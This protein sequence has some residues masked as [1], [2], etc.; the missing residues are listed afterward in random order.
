MTKL[1]KE[2]K[3]MTPENIILREATIE[4]A[5]ALLSIY[6]PYVTDTPITFE[7]E[8]PSVEEFSHRISSTLTRYPYLV[9]EMDGVAAGYAYASAFHPRA[10]YGWCAETSIYL[11]NSLHGQGIGTLLYQKLEQ[12]LSAQHILNLNACITYPNPKSIAFH[13]KFGY[14]PTAHFHNCGFKLNRWYDMIWMEKMLGE[15]QI[16]PAEFLTFPTVRH[17]FFS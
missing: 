9:A 8:I 16:P 4:D 11:S 3:E 5:A 17:L 1:K 13:E 14:T 15:H 7:Y 6:A 12:I 10:A 2:V